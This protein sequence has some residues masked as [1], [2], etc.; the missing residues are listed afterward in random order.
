MDAQTEA[1]RS[2]IIRAVQ[3][4]SVVAWRHIN[5]YG[6]YDFSDEKLKDS[7]GLVMPLIQKLTVV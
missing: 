4:G 5:F 2:E 7:I 6:E 1:E 3:E